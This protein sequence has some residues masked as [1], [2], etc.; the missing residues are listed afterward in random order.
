M[1]HLT[2]VFARSWTF[3]NVLLVA[4]LIAVQGASPL[5]AGTVRRYVEDFATQQFRDAATTTAD[6][7]SAAGEIQ[8]FPFVPSIVAGFGPPGA[9]FTR[10][11]A[12]DGN[13]L[14]MVD[15]AEGLR[16]FDVTDPLNPVLAG[17]WVSPPDGIEAFASDVVIAGDM[18][19]VADGLSGLQI[20]DISDTAN[21][22]R[23]G[24]Y[25]TTGFARGVT[26]A[27]DFAYVAQSAVPP[28]T[29]SGLFVVDISN[30]ALPALA[31]SLL[32]PGLPIGVSVDGDLAYVAGGT[33]GLFT[34][35]VSNPASPALLGNLPTPTLS[36]S[37]VV[38]GKHA[39]MA[40]AQSGLYV[41]N[42]TNPLTPTLAK[43]YDTPDISFGVALAG[44]VLYVADG[45][46]GLLEFN[47]EDA[48]NPVLA[49]TIDTADL[50]LG[51]ALAGDYA[52]VSDGAAGLKVIKTSEAVRPIPV[53]AT[54][55]AMNAGGVV[56][57]GNHALV[58]DGSFGLRSVDITDPALPVVVGGAASVLSLAGDVA[59]SGDHVYASTGGSGQ[60]EIFL[61][62]DAANPIHL[63]NFDT[64]S[65]TGSMVIRGDRGYLANG[66]A[67]FTV[68]DL[69]NPPVPAIVGN[70]STPN[71]AVA[72]DAAGDMAFVTVIAT[73]L[74]T[75]DISNPALPVTAGGYT[76]GAGGN[77]IE[78]H[79]DEAYIASSDG[80][81]VFDITDP[82]APAP[83]AHLPTT[84]G[85]GR[86]VAVAGDYAVVTTGS[87]PPGAVLVIDVRDPANP[88]EVGSYPTT[89]ALDVALSGDLAYVADGTSG[90]RVFE[91]FERAFGL[92][93]NIAQSTNVHAAGDD[94]IRVRLAATHN[95]SIRWEVS[96]DGGGAWRDVVPNGSWVKPP[97]PGSDLRWRSSHVYA[98]AR[99]NPA[100]STLELEWLYPFAAIDSI[101]DVP[102]D[103]GGWVNVH[104]SRSGHDFAD[105][106]L[107]V[108]YA[109]RRQVEGA[110]NDWE[111]VGTVT[112]QRQDEYIATVPTVPDPADT[113]FSV[114]SI[115]ART[116]DPLAFF[117]S[118]PDS[119]FSVDN[120]VAV[121]IADFNAAY[122]A[123][124]VRLRWRVAHANGLQG[125]HVY[126]SL[127]RERNYHRVNGAMLPASTAGVYTDTAIE[128]GASYWY[129]LGAVDRDGE[130]L[131]PPVSVTIPRGVFRLFQNH[132]NP[133]NPSTTISYDVPL[134]TR[135]TLR[136]FDVSGGLI[137]TLVN[138]A[139]PAG[140]R[141]VTW[142]GRDNSG[143]RVA[144]GI[145][146]YRLH[147]NGFSG[148][149]KMVLIE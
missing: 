43:V 71:F 11:L 55:S 122:V 82:T 52:Y 83:L 64:G 131:S 48:V 57:R 146:F 93:N 78:V 67:G 5:Y 136:I 135:V 123:N 18:A 117:D 44:D 112:A 74:R 119:G 37:I 61:I 42:V 89:N 3:L 138:G 34:V 92:A 111:I 81:R 98:V 39:Y 29:D 124:A 127:E 60:L 109:V 21:P 17:T 134:R 2:T 128:P 94:I 115:R 62:G 106:T 40:T 46:T 50:A 108:D 23:V 69:A 125:F 137:R 104:F 143:R 8:L 14:C 75:I 147:A 97:Q 51:V 47:I 53:G 70:A 132:P 87:N 38:A 110:P 59:L 30:P 16:V 129:R 33:G 90:L 142:D 133:F 15:G 86:G 4:T 91:V 73:G 72:A 41:V 77:D 85:V 140:R 114:Y 105:T 9:G 32:L 118:P 120:T 149:R 63:F 54:Q 68:L 1:T 145:Y 144:S 56:I 113:V 103:T 88:V 148:T 96:A 36:R 121:L 12:I 80:L 79:G 139:Q 26:V 102:N 24:H 20:I 100:A 130:F 95:D 27:G 6:W 99:T 101:V 10:D 25:Q 107:I 45:A 28:A 49:H 126:R 116:S 13:I 22:F 7:N 65:E 66:I 35:T 19:L 58:A 76:D 31:G 84:T 141:S